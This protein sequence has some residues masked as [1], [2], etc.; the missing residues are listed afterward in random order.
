VSIPSELTSA[1]AD[2][3]VIERELGRGG[4]ATVYLARDIRHRRAVALKLLDPELG[5]ALGVDR[6]LAEIRVTA[7]LQHPNLLPLF[8]SGDVNGQP[9]YV[10]PYVDGESLRQR[11]DREK[12][13]PVDEAVRIA[14]AVAGAL[15]YAH[16]HGV[17]HRD[18]K[19][20]NILLQAGQPV[21]ADFG[22][23]LAV[24][25]A[26]GVRMT[27][28]GVSL[29][30]PQY[31]SPEQATGD[32]TI[33]ARS[34]IYSLAAVTYEMLTGDP[35]HTG[36][37]MQAVIAR[38]LTERPRGIRTVRPN[39]PAYAATAIER[40]LEKLPAD[41]WATAREFAEAL[42]GRLVADPAR[43]D[44]SSLPAAL[45]T[46]AR[47][48]ARRSRD[49]IVLG[50]LA[51]AGIGVALAAWGWTRGPDEIDGR[52]VRFTIAP[53]GPRDDVAPGTQIAI[54][55]DGRF[56]AFTLR[57]E[58]G[59]QRLAIREVG[60]L[61]TRVIREADPAIGPFFS[62]DGT[63]LGF[64]N[65][66]ARIVRRV[67]LAGGPAVDVAE[68]A[69]VLGAAWAPGDVIIASVKDR[70]MT[71]PSAGGQFRPIGRG[72]GVD[73]ERGQRSP[74]VLDDG[75]T[76]VYLSWRGS[77]QTSRI[78]VMSLSTGRATVLDIG[79]ASPIGVVDGYLIYG[80]SAGAIMAVAFD[81]AAHRVTGRP[82]QVVDQADISQSGL[83][84]AAVSRSGSLAY[85]SAARTSEVVL[86]DVTGR[87]RVLLAEPRDYAAPRFSPDGSRLALAIASSRGSDVWIHDIASGTP[88]K[89][90][91][92]GERNS[93]PEWTPDGKRVLYASSG[94]GGSSLWW[95]NSDFSGVREL[96]ERAPETVNAGVISPDGRTLVYW[97][98]TPTQP[99]D[100]FY[101]R[102]EGDT[103]SKPIEA[104]PAAEIS[105]KFSPDGKWVAYGS[106]KDGTLQVY[107]QPFPPTGAIYQVT[108]TGGM[109]PVWSRDGKR[110]FYVSN[111]RLHA[112]TIR[113]SPDFAVTAR[114]P[115]FEGN[116]L[117]NVPQHA[118]YDVSP[119]GKSF[120]LLQAVG[121]ND[122]IV[123]AHDW[124]YELRERMREKRQK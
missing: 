6:F 97:R 20:E 12:Q 61:A 24:S 51:L 72:A 76:V 4:M 108:P 17:V 35:P 70:L 109:A 64:S 65:P 26:G 82:V 85:V 22:I 39:V 71:V 89:L 55:P 38:V 121:P 53:G 18:L 40:A 16:A 15:E 46:R 7:N 27:Q 52:T 104:T 23:A 122:Q 62:P 124:K 56:I 86:S 74:R 75:E 99:V 11:I 1:V 114:T 117:L 48:G 36:S 115:M 49:P 45:G 84:R 41:R 59:D 21:V 54:S 87:T 31:M 103:T 102:L 101:R 37:T 67:P 94:S 10:M 80:T 68:G 77:M 96:A 5:A 81:V 9:Y 105:P 19:P 83:V 43:L 42:Q 73:G 8:D 30:T 93:R 118:N 29:G 110:I 33:D 2:R 78:G 13:L 120:A 119:D 116:Y 58:A 91:S 47:S 63:S 95:R 3:Y 34:D 106:N 123:V 100:I 112:A 111:G 98:S 69:P 60:Q 66:G 44:A 92:E 32:Q 88:T 57:T 90:T 50:A 79:G 28:T 113:T 25:N 14:V 107:V